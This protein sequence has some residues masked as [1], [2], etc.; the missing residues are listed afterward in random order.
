ME[1]KKQKKVS[2][3]EFIDTNVLAVEPDERGKAKVTAGLTV[4]KDKEVI[5]KD[6]KQIDKVNNE[7]QV[8]EAEEKEER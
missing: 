3:I 2:G 4:T 5:N 7:T 8:K 6:Q 1:E